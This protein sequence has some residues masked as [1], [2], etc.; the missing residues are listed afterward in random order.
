MKRNTRVGSPRAETGEQVVKQVKKQAKVASSW[1]E[2]AG[3]CRYDEQDFS[4]EPD[5]EVVEME[6]VRMEREA[7]SQE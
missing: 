3:D 5:A 4:G 1:D 6:R 7:A 2:I